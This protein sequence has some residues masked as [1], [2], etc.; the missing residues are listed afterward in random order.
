MEKKIPSNLAKVG[1]LR[2][3]PHNATARFAPGDLLPLSCLETAE[4]EGRRD[5]EAR[6]ANRAHQT[7]QALL[8]QRVMHIAMATVAKDAQSRVPQS[9]KETGGPC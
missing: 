5:T 1:S 8:P 2:L 3:T 9:G 6:T 7:L 4:A